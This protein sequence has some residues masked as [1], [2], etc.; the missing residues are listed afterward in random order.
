MVNIRMIVCDPMAGRGPT[1]MLALRRG[2]H[3]V[4]L[5]ISK[6][7]VKE[8]CDYLMRY[9][10]YHKI[11]HKKSERRC[12]RGKIL[13]GLE[14]GLNVGETEGDVTPDKYCP[15]SKRNKAESYALY[16]RIFRYSYKNFL[17][18]RLLIRGENG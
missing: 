17:Y 1:L 9:L 5:E 10:E 8:A 7:D 3:G 11:K 2:Y 14:H 4:G 6:A 16:K 15:Y 18:T 12:N 13:Q